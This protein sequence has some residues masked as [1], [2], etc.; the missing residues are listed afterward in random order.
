VCKEDNLQA[1]KRNLLEIIEIGSLSREGLSV[2]VSIT[3]TERQIQALEDLRD[4]SDPFW[5]KTHKVL[6]RNLDSQWEL[7]EIFSEPGENRTLRSE[8]AKNK[9]PKDLTSLQTS[10]QR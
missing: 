2:G 8:K 4:L 3:W 5:K 9:L 6:K 7:H 1:M 10:H